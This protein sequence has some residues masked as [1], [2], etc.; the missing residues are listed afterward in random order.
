MRKALAVGV[1]LLLVLGCT[2]DG[3]DEPAGPAASTEPP[4]SAADRGARDAAR[5]FLDTYVDDDGRVVRRDQGGDTVSEGQSYGLLLALVA[6]D[7]DAF[8]RI[9]AWTED[10]LQRDDGLLAFRAG[11]DGEVLDPAAASDADV[12]V[13]WALALAGE[14]EG[15]LGDALLDA[16]LV[17]L[18]EGPVLAAGDWATGQPATLNPSYWVF[19]AFARLAESGDD[20]WADV[21]RASAEV[22]R[23]VTDD[24]ALLPPDWARVD[25]STVTATPAP[26][27]SSPVVRYSLDAQRL[28]VWLATSPAAEDRALAAAAWPVLSSEGIA[29]ALSLSPEG[30]VI[31]GRPH[32][33]PLV[34]AAAAAHAA[35]RPAD[36]DRLLDA[37]ADQDGAVP[38]YY[39]AAWVAL[40]RALLQTDLLIGARS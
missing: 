6:G 25:G 28:L 29:A 36:R 16:A 4:L 12:V 8:G 15:R 30:D 10:H 35:G 23:A 20:E 32:P 2:G 39:G 31:D 9:W 19:P 17:D 21:G 27:G 5:A 24:G 18:P 33:L 14:E 26:D 13:A 1:A 7:D 3:D 11:P 34:A 40:G 22:A 37:A 38:T